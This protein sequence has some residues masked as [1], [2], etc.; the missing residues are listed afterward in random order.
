MV[1][2]KLV[3]GPSH[4]IRN[5]VFFLLREREKRGREREGERDRQT[6]TERETD[7]QRDKE[8]E[9]GAERNKEKLLP[10]VFAPSLFEGKIRGECSNIMIAR[11]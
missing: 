10:A 2:I 4:L 7:R 8:R 1:C 11:F 5:W 9:N 3:A 6:E